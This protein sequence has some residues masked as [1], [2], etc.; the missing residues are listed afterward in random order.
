MRRQGARCCAR[1]QMGYSWSWGWGLFLLSNSPL[2]WGVTLFIWVILA[3]PKK[4]Q[5][6]TILGKS[7]AKS[8]AHLDT[9]F[10]IS[11]KL[12]EG[13]RVGRVEDTLRYLSSSVDSQTS[14]ITLLCRISACPHPS[15][16]MYATCHVI[17]CDEI[18][19]ARCDQDIV[20]CDQFWWSHM[21][22]KKRSS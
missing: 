20:S 14:T 21:T 4:I 16:T 5:K 18:Q 6:N 7:M 15:C 3:F 2:I 11:R 12:L 13:H 9:I 22:H 10:H 1:A 17:W 8:L 19:D